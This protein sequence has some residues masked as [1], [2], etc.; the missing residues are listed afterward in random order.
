MHTI[1]QDFEV[2]VGVEE[3]T[4]KIKVEDLLHEV[5]VVGDRVDNLDLEGTIAASAD[6]SKI[7]VWELGNLVGCQGFGSF[8]DLVGDGFRSRGTIGKVVLDTEIL[9][10]T[11]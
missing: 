2:L 8:V 10:G 5:N 9:G 6:L 11:C 4:D 1:E 7:D 3:V